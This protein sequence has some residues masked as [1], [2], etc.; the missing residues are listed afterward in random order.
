MLPLLLTHV[1]AVWLIL[2]SLTDSPLWSSSLLLLFPC[3]CV[4]VLSISLCLR[5]CL[6]KRDGRCK[7]GH[8]RTILPF[9]C[10]SPPGDGWH[11]G[12]VRTAGVSVSVSHGMINISWQSS[13]RV[14]V[15]P[16]GIYVVPM[17]TISLFLTISNKSSHWSPVNQ[18]RTN[19]QCVIPS[20]SST[21]RI[22]VGYLHPSCICLR[23][24][25]VR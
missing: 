15:K 22:C 17:W 6:I 13:S 11:M 1:Q 18:T 7:G 5:M 3:V 4:T 10:V 20:D 23:A 19:P 9:C 12:T 8:K 14:I 25:R 24:A 16:N 21:L 2:L